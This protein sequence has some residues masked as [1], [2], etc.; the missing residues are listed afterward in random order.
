V[1]TGPTRQVI[2]T[3]RHPYTKGLLRSIPLLS[4]P[5]RPIRPIEGQVPELV[6]LPP[7]CRFLPR[8]P[9]AGPDCHRPVPLFAVGLGREARCVRVGA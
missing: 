4:D 1:E 6:D 7:V 9:E 8:C 2:Q 5:D 3:P